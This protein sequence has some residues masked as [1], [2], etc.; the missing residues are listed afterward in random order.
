MDGYLSEYAD[1]PDLLLE[2]VAEMLADMTKYAAISTTPTNRNATSSY[3]D[4]LSNSIGVN[5]NRS[6]REGLTLAAS[7]DY[8]YSR[9]GNYHS[10][11]SEQYLNY[12]SQYSSATG[13]SLGKTR[14]LNAAL[15]VKWELDPMTR[16]DVSGTWNC[17][18]GRHSTDQRS[19]S[20]SQLPR[21]AC[22][23]WRSR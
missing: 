11:N 2:K 7:T 23:D 22:P 8:R 1:D 3:K 18:N 10:A 21:P 5:L 20:S 4:N 15:E 17:R 16:L 14:E 19:A 13:F 12:G 6:L 9:E